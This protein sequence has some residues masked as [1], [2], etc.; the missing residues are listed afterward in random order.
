MENILAFKTKPVYVCI[1]KYEK[2]SFIYQGWTISDNY[3]LN[4]SSPEHSQYSITIT[5]PSISDED[6]LNHYSLQGKKNAELI[7]ELIPISGLPSLNSPKNK[8]FCNNQEFVDY[9]SAP[10]GWSSNYTT[11]QSMLNREKDNKI[12]LVVTF[13]GIVHFS[14]LE[15]TPLPD[16]QHMLEHYDD[17]DESIKFLLF[18]N[19]SILSAN[20]INVFMLIGKAL[21]II[22]EIGIHSEPK[23]DKRKP[24]RSYFPE[25]SEVLHDKT[26]SNLFELSNSRKESRHFVNDKCKNNV[27]AHVSLSKEER[28]DLYRCSII[29]TLNV[30][31]D[32]FGLSRL[33]VSTQ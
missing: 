30:I 24:I 18:L 19:N 32:A 7:T 5:S 31:R 1:D 6:E 29:L 2:Y 33:P 21:E 9:N 8:S 16:I 22:Y 13:E 11:I 15:H 12:S 10:S 28:T 20:D 14:M 26:F 4:E 3:V 23:W 17:I 25:L 27:E